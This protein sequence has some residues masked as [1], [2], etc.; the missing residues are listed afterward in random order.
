MKNKILLAAMI[1]ALLI[2]GC[3]KTAPTNTT[4]QPREES[5]AVATAKPSMPAPSRE[6]ID[7]HQY[8]KKTRIKKNDADN[9]GN[10]VSFSISKI[11]NRKIGN[12][13]LYGRR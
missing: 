13:P 11:E 8:L 10:E 6:A 4:Q 7:Y 1:V 12:P 9:F 3:G 2:A 5:P